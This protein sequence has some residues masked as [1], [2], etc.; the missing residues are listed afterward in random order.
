MC[1][2]RLNHHIKRRLWKEQGTR[3]T[4]E[5]LSEVRRAA[6]E[7][8]ELP[9]GDDRVALLARTLS[10]F[11]GIGN[12][13]GEVAALKTLWAAIG[14]SVR[15]GGGGA[16]DDLLRRLV[17]L[18]AQIAFFDNSRALHRQ[19]LS[20]ASRLPSPFLG[21]WKRPPRSEFARLAIGPAAAL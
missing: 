5:Y 10:H 4:D 20:N 9:K 6:Q 15:D 17:G 7:A 8:E 2:A 18:V 12:T 3:F 13:Y 16:H 14:S 1:A 11:C 21:H 19:L